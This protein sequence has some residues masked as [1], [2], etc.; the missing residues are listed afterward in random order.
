MKPL[1]LFKLKGLPISILGVAEPLAQKDTITEWV[2][3]DHCRIVEIMTKEGSNIEWRSDPLFPCT[4]P[5]RLLE[6]SIGQDR[7]LT[8]KV[9]SDRHLMEIYEK[10]LTKERAAASGIQM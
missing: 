3:S 10:Q 7:E 2:I 9:T 1:R 8:N 5:F 6:A 4:T